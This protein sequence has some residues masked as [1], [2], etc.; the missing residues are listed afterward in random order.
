M[1]GF[2]VPDNMWLLLDTPSDP[3]VINDVKQAFPDAI[4]YELF[5][6]TEVDCIREQGPL[7]VR[8]SVDHELVLMS[9]EQVKAWPGVFI[10]S[11]VPVEELLAHL[12]RMLIVRLSDQHKSLLTYYN[13]QTASYFF[14]AMD[15]DELS[16]WMGPAESITWFGGTWGDKVE[17]MQ[18]RQYVVNPKRAVSPLTDEPWLSLRQEKKLQQCFVERHAY[19]WSHTF[20]HNYRR[21]LRH[22]HEGLSHGFNDGAILDEWLTLRALFPSASMPEILPGDSQRAR[23]DNLTNYWQGPG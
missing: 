19:Y 10:I 14:D 17:G 15:V 13:V 2:I 4:N 16:C 18:G 21:T 11:P 9:D 7:L 22:L 3:A 12:R 23:F 20:G 5:A 8:L 6:E 1:S